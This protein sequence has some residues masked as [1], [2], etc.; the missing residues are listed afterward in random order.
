MMPRRRTLPPATSVGLA[1]LTLAWSALVIDEKLV[2]ATLPGPGTLQRVLPYLM[3]A[4]LVA[5]LL[6]RRPTSWLDEASWVWTVLVLLAALLLPKVVAG[7]ITP[8]V[9]PAVAV[10]AAVV[11]RWP[12]AALALI[13]FLSAALGSLHAFFNFPSEKAIA[14]CL[15]GL[16]VASLVSA[17]LRG[18]RPIRLSVSLSLFVGYLAVT[19]GMMVLAPS[20]HVAYLGF[21]DS[22]WFMLLVP[23]IA[24]AGWGDAVFDRVSKAVLLVVLAA[25]LYTIYRVIVGPA[26]QEFAI[27]ATS[28]FNFTGATLK[29]GGSFNTAQDM[30]TW[31]AAVAPFC[32]AQMLYRRGRWQ[33]IAAAALG[34]AVVSAIESQTRIAL[35]GIVAGIVVVLALYERSHG[36]PG[37]RLNVTLL[38]TVAGIALIAGGIS[39]AGNR[40]PHPFAGILHPT[41]DASYK[42]RTYKWSRALNALDTHPFGFGVGTASAGEST[43]G[44]YFGLGDTS[45]DNGY[46][47]IALE[48]G[49]V[50]MVLFIAAV[51]GMLVALARTAIGEHRPRDSTLAIG[52]AGTLTSFLLVMLAED[53][54]STTRAV[55]VWLI[56]GLGMAVAVRARRPP[57][58]AETAEL[59]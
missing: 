53:A 34:L 51:L 56:V 55:P 14:L 19:A 30:G 33:L 40:S 38:A 10:A 1:M 37:L 52:A 45:I 39:I 47:R 16:L 24:W 57:P 49:L 6:I 20:L 43:A 25:A 3:P 11:G 32:F 44:V 50:I 42:A 27:F 8:F 28:P 31:M 36:F 13:A 23:V 35:V 12:V 26:A 58:A 48:Q 21:K 7:S 18:S 59:A 17:L 54:S 15:V 46:L 29:P 41:S 5:L 4:L 2:G 9:L 22:T